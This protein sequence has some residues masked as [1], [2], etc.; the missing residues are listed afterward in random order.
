[1]CWSARRMMAVVYAALVGMLADHGLGNPFPPPN[2]PTLTEISFADAATLSS[3]SYLSLNAAN[4]SPN[5]GITLATTSQCPSPVLSLG[6]TMGFFSAQVPVATFVPLLVGP[7]FAPYTP[8]PI[9]VIVNTPPTLVVTVNSH[10]QSVVDNS[11]FNYLHIAY[12]Y[13]VPTM[14]SGAASCSSCG[15]GGASGA[16]NVMQ[17]AIERVHRY[18]DQTWQSSFGPGVYSNYDVQLAALRR[19]PADR[20]AVRSAGKLA[21]AIDGGGRS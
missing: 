15:G 12:D 16:T 2:P 4:V 20:R 13:Q 17:L 6:Q 5:N 9:T 8:V 19:L 21:G 1:M 11:S 3:N 14:P 7:S 18:R 10:N